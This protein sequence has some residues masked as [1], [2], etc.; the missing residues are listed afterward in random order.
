MMFF[1]VLCRQNIYIYIYNTYKQLTRTCDKQPVLFGWCRFCHVAL[2][3]T[4]SM[5]CCER[6]RSSPRLPCSR[7]SQRTGWAWGKDLEWK[8]HQKV[9][10]LW[11][12]AGRQH[13]FNRIQSISIASWFGKCNAKKRQQRQDAAPYIQKSSFISEVFS[14]KMFLVLAGIART[15]LDA[16]ARAF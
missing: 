11:P 4:S 12:V 16:T 3:E 15:Y 9:P 1:V 13:V 2:R 7:A 8:T 6:P 14:W 10:A 5:Q